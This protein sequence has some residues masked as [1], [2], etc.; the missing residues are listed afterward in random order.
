MMAIRIRKF[1]PHHMDL[2]TQQYNLRLCFNFPL[3]ILSTETVYDTNTCNAR[4]RREQF[5]NPEK[6]KNNRSVSSR[7]QMET[8]LKKMME[9]RSLTATAMCSH[10]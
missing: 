4:S 7:D 9:R 6:P 5:Q 10:A 2:H 8:I 1:Y 3:K